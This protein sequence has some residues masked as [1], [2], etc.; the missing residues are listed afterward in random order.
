MEREYPEFIAADGIKVVDVEKLLVNFRCDQKQPC[1]KQDT[2]ELLFGD[3][4]E[5][6]CRKTGQKKSAE[7][8]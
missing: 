7:E 6:I 4:A 3:I 1:E 8:K 5:L 2:I